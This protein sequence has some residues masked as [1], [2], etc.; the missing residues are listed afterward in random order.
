MKI[1]AGNGVSGYVDGD[2]ASAKFDRPKS[3]A[4]DLKGNIYVADSH[5]HAIRKIGK[6]GRYINCLFRQALP[7]FA[8]SQTL[9]SAS[10][11]GKTM[12]S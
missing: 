9:I 1:L 3:F 2:F 5:N 7:S 11:F 4:I 6:S 10:V 12:K 8:C